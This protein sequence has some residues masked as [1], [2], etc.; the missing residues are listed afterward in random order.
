MTGTTH[1]GEIS[2]DDKKTNL[3]KICD[4]SNQQEDCTE[5]KARI[6]TCDLLKPTTGH[7]QRD[8]L[9]SSRVLW[10]PLLAERGSVATSGNCTTSPEIHANHNSLTF[11][12][13]ILLSGSG[14]STA[15]L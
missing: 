9:E 10:S 6:T 12:C 1:V 2:Q 15:T 14:R 5:L 13:H 4:G 11:R 8:W 7:E 3:K